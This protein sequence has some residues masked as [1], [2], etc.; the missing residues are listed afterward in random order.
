[1]R[2]LS[3]TTDY[4]EEKR[5]KKKKDCQKVSACVE[6]ALSRY[7]E[8]VSRVVF[9]K[10]EADY[11]LGKSDIFGNPELFIKALKSSLRFGSYY[12]EKTMVSELRSS[13]SLKPRDGSGFIETISEIKELGT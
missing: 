7:D 8:K 13:F 5:K 12:V 9:S 1:M 4:E 3:L 11:N 2:I 10:F 6:R